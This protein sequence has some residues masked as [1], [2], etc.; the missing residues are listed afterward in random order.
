MP[1]YIERGNYYTSQEAADYLG[2][3]E[4][5]IRRLIG[6]GQ[7]TAI[8]IGKLSWLLAADELRQRKKNPPPLGRPKS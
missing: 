3:S 7:L 1:V 2:I 6:S 4:A 8:R 5:Y